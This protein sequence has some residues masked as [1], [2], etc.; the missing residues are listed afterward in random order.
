[1]EAPFF[2]ESFTLN[3]SS[4]IKIDNCPLLVVA[5]VVAIDTNCMSF[6]V[7]VTLDFDN[8]AILEV[9]ELFVLVLE[10]LPPSTVGTPDLHIAGSSTALVVP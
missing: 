7:F 8:L 6:F 9:D 3:L 1:M 10:D 2:V 4:F 5:L